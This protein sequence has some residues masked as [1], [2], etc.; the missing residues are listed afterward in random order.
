MAIVTSS[1]PR[2][3]L[4]VGVS[5]AGGLALTCVVSGLRLGIAIVTSSG[6]SVTI[7]VG[8]SSGGMNFASL[9]AEEGGAGWAGS[10]FTGENLNTWA[11]FQRTTI[12]ASLVMTPGQKS[13]TAPYLNRRSRRLF[14]ITD[15]LL[16]D[17]AT[18]ATMGL[19]S[20]PVKGYRMP[21]ARGMPRPL[22]KNANM[23]F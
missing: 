1:G 11:M 14:K 10:G 17:I 16:K 22:Y 3:R 15:T 9:S 5:S 12:R 4:P 2:V 7:P 23:R 13:A 19:S 8:V 21:A 20:Q 18:L 6:P